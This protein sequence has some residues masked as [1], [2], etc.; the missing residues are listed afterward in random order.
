VTESQLGT[1]SFG[2]TCG[3]GNQIVQGQASTQVITPTVS[4][5]ANAASL[6][7]NQTLQLRWSANFGS[8]SSSGGPGGGGWGNLLPA[9]G[10]FNT[11]SEVPGTFTYIVRCAGAQ[12]STQVTFT[13]TLQPVTLTTSA[14]SS[15]VNGRVT[16]TW[17]WTV[18]PNSSCTASGG[19]PGDGWSGGPLGE[20]GS[21]GVTSAAAG[22]IAYSITC[23]YQQVQSHAQTQVTYMPVGAAQPPAATPVVTLTASASNETVGSDVKLSWS[24]ENASECTASG[25]ASGDGW[26]GTLPLSG[27]MS[28]TESSAG[29]FAYSLECS[30]APPA[31][32]AKATVN[33]TASSS[34]SS[35]AGAA[36]GGGGGGGAL[37]PIFLLILSAL[38]LKR[39][40]REASKH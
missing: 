24:S 35:G 6:P 30:G 31:A 23:T 9:Q 27:S 26:S 13:G 40:Q 37:E 32:T 36:G 25:G 10:G 19:I 5:T 33:F 11:T 38:G 12:A 20:E 14:S 2:I 21:K 15:P 4:M 29:S 18:V 8:C 3:S 22:T 7:I 17:N 16:L 34:G 1:V 28:V 39:W